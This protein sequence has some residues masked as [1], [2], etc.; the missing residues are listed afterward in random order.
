MRLEVFN[1]DI[2]TN[3]MRTARFLNLS[4][5]E[6]TILKYDDV[7]AMPCMFICTY[8]K[9]MF[10]RQKKNV[11]ADTPSTRSTHSCTFAFTSS[12]TKPNQHMHD[13]VLHFSYLGVQRFRVSFHLHKL[14]LF[15]YK[16]CIF[17]SCFLE[18]ELKSFLGGR[19]AALKNNGTCTH[20]GRNIALT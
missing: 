16:L 5:F 15:I 6:I 17:I 20:P 4:P 7:P 12:Y 8:S 14:T 9:P 18:V 19:F 1:P 2:H 3:K 11:H 10:Y 13:S